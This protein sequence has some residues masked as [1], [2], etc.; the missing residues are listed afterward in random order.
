VQVDSRWRLSR[1]ARDGEFEPVTCL[2]THPR[3]LAKTADPYQCAHLD[4][5]AKY[6]FELTS[7]HIFP[8][9][10]GRSALEVD[11]PCLTLPSLDHRLTESVVSLRVSGISRHRVLQARQHVRLP[12][13]RLGQ[14]ASQHPPTRR[15]DGL[16]GLVAED[17]K[18]VSGNSKRHPALGQC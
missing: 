9:A 18:I 15:I 17:G 13:P 5:L 12:R 1:V 4:S 11:L 7:Q 8:D 10:E 16:G 3:L 6:A 2:G 14:S